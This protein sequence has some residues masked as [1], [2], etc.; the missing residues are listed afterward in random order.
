[1]SSCHRRSKPAGALLILCIASGLG[2]GGCTSL[3]SEGA[4]TTAG[5][6]GT[7]IAGAVTRNAAVASGIGL[8]VLAA[9]EAGVKAVERD[10]HG[11]QQDVIAEAAGE[12]ETGQ[13]A[14]WESRHRIQIESNQAGR[15]T[16]SRVIGAA[17]FRCKE[18][19]FSVDRIKDKGTVSAFYI[20][21]I[22][23]DSAKWRWASA[24]PATARWGALQ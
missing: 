18:I 12:L 14:H 3:L 9:G 7:A 2:L 15:V 5:V 8:G 19:V 22:C 10:Y 17:A 6:G 11:D 16:V 1:M 21:T 13:V 24:E 4:A 23:K 20:A